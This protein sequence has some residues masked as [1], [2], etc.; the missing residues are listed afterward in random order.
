MGDGAVNTR[1]V[2]ETIVRLMK[3][4]ADSEDDAVSDVASS[5]D[6]EITVS[7]GLLLVK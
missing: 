7:L 1:W 4:I 3:G 6:G 2:A 5:D